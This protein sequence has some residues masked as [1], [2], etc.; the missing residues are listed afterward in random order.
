MHSADF[1]SE[2]VGDGMDGDNF[3]SDL[4]KFRQHMNQHQIKAGISE[5]WDRDGTMKSGNG[6]GPIGQGVKANS[7]YAHIHPMPFYHFN[8]PESEAWSYIQQATQWVL[9]NVGLPTM[10]TET[11]WAW[12]KTDHNP[13]KSDVGVAQYTNYWKTFD[14]NC[15]W[16][17]QKNVGWFLHAWQGEDTF[18][19]VKSDGS[20]VIPNWRP[21]KC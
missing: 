12:G 21:R 13:G 16:F 19:M 9:D 10:I 3:V 18:D 2:P 17:K 8:N 6:L 20:Y 1:G 5:D 7:D 4:G 15:E 14:N 11:M